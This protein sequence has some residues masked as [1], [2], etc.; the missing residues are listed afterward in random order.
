MSGSLPSILRGSLPSILLTNDRLGPKFKSSPEM[1][2][3]IRPSEV[4]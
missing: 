1:G 4:M 2:D 3:T